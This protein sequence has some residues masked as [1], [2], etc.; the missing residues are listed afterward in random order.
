VRPVR[1]QYTA[2]VVRDFVCIW[3]DAVALDVITSAYVTSPTSRR[4]WAN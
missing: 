2:I 1:A 3:A 4:R